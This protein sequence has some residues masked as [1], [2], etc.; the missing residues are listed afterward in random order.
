MFTN[1]GDSPFLNSKIDE[2]MTILR[3]T[4]YG[5]KATALPNKPRINLHIFDVQISPSGQ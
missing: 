3:N 2:C 4:F 5:N 1:N